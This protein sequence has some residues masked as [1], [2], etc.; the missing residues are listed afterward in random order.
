MLWLLKDSVVVYQSYH[1]RAFFTACSCFGS[2]SDSFGCVAH[3]PIISKR[4]DSADAT[5][6]LVVDLPKL[7]PLHSATTSQY[8]P[9][10]SSYKM[11]RQQEVGNS[12]LYQ[13][14]M[15]ALAADQLALCDT[16]LHQ[17]M[18]QV[19]QRFLISQQILPARRLLRQR[20]ESQL[21][22]N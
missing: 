4:L 10:T 17:K 2:H 3:V 9:T 21:Y 7:S 8:L 15:S 22:G 5:V 11:T 13:I 1:T 14:L 6:F 20:R 19:L 18:M 16:R 12:L